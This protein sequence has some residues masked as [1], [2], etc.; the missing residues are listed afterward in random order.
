MIC[1]QLFKILYERNYTLNKTTKLKKRNRI[2][3]ATL[4]SFFVSF[5]ASSFMSI[6]ADL[7]DTYR[8]LA[9]AIAVVASLLF[10]YVIYKQAK[11]SIKVE[12]ELDILKERIEK[13][14]G[15]PK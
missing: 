15:K 1:S 14:E 4:V 13:L 8:E 3:N 7:R 5:I 11:D 12:E 9:I 2:L 10:A 6:S